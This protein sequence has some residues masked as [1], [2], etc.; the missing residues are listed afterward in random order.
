MS[1]FA[2]WVGGPNKVFAWILMAL[3]ACVFLPFLFWTQFPRPQLKRDQSWWK[4]QSGSPG[5]GPPRNA[6][7]AAVLSRL[8]IGVAVMVALWLLLRSR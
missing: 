1:I 5:A 3:V 8:V 6:S 4:L 2:I 7:Q